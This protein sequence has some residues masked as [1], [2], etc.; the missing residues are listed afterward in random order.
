MA[1]FL[2]DE[3][4]A[5]AAQPAVD[6]VELAIER[7][8]SGG[9]DGEVRYMVEIGPDAARV[10]AVGRSGHDPDLTISSD[11]DTA[12]AIAQGR[13][14]TQKAL[15]DGQLRVRGNLSRLSPGATEARSLDPLPANLRENTTY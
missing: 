1:R 3:W 9:P 14:S 7:V 12:V 5:A 8:V 15:M 2:S 4:F 10:V 11:W 13:L 6:P